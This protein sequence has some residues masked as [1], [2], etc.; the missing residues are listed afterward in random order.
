MLHQVTCH[1]LHQLHIYL[2]WSQPH[3]GRWKLGLSEN[4]QGKTWE[5][6]LVNRHYP[7]NSM[8]VNWGA[9]SI[10]NKTTITGYLNWLEWWLIMIYH[11]FTNFYHLFAGCYIYIPSWWFGTCLIFPYIGKNNPNWLSYFFRGVGSTTN[12]VKMVTYPNIRHVSYTHVESS[13]PIIGFVAVV[14]MVDTS[15]HTQTHLCVVSWRCSHVHIH[16]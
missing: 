4:T 3:F 12:Q 11:D 14:V 10:K 16:V 7:S 9:I 13:P 8:V 6:L 15:T 2:C 5:N 1:Q